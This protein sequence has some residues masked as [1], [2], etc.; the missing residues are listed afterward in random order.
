MVFWLYNLPINILI[1]NYRLAKFL[2]FWPEVF[3]STGI[4]RLTMF[5]VPVAFF[6]DYWLYCWHRLDQCIFMLETKQNYFQARAIDE[7]REWGFL[8][9]AWLWP[10]RGRWYLWEVLSRLRWWWISSSSSLKSFLSST[11]H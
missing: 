11:K 7:E 3:L 10:S 5:L 4:E 9:F 2:F 1:T 6:K 8:S